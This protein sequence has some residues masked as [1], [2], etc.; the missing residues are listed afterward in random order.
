MVEDWRPHAQAQREQ[1][2]GVVTDEQYLVAYS[3]RLLDRVPLATSERTWEAHLQGARRAATGLVQLADTG[4]PVSIHPDDQFSLFNL[5]DHYPDID[6]YVDEMERIGTALAETSAAKSGPRLAW[7][8]AIRRWVFAENQLTI[9]HIPWRI[10]ALGVPVIVL[11]YYALWA[12]NVIQPEPYREVVEA[13]F[14]EGYV[15][16][17]NDRYNVLIMNSDDTYHIASVA[18]P[19]REPGETFWICSVDAAQFDRASPNT[20][21]QYECEPD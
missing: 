11:G 20:L 12:L 6:E 5:M 3:R 1:I 14:A 18:S 10:L 15:W 8:T 13:A 9:N 16:R 7:L 21:L 4:E 2:F 19:M 17:D